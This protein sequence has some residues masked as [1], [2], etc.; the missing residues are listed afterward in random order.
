MRHSPHSIGRVRCELE[1]PERT[2]EEERHLG[3][4]D[5]DPHVDEERKG[6][7]P[8]QQTQEDEHAADNLHGS[9]ERT[10]HLRKR[11]PDPHE[12]AH[13]PCGRI[14]KFL[15]ALRQEHDP[16]HHSNEK[17]GRRGVGPRDAI[18]QAHDR[19]IFR[20]THRRTLVDG[21]RSS[22]V[23]PAA[24]GERKLQALFS[25]HPTAQ[26]TSVHDSHCPFTCTSETVFPM[27]SF[28]SLTAPV[29][30]HS[31]APQSVQTKWG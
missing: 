17:S 13:A 6:R 19:D 24:V 26:G 30:R 28:P 18:E 10:H 1:A 11:D 5:R 8:R 16:H 31:I 22:V 14:E 27:S 25:G 7:K 21:S 3:R 23:D 29:D 15:D 9:D 12:T 2:S 20:F 4:D